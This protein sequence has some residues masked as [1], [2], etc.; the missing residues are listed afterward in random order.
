MSA[1]IS[2]PS[3]MDTMSLVLATSTNQEL[4]EKCSKCL[5]SLIEFAEDMDNCLPF[6][7]Q[8]ATRCVQFQF[9]TPK[10]LYVLIFFWH[11]WQ[12]K[13]QTNWTKKWYWTHCLDTISQNLWRGI[14]EALG[15]S[16]KTRDFSTALA[17]T[18]L[19]GDILA[20]S[21]ITS[22][23]L[24]FPDRED[25]MLEICDKCLDLI[26]VCSGQSDKKE[27]LK[28]CSTVAKLLCIVWTSLGCH[29]LPSFEALG[30]VLIN[31]R[32]VAAGIN[33]RY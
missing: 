2:D 8:C 11:F 17:F 19:M 16:C 25:L 5:A 9:F 3:V 20:T 12:M 21:E 6:F 32:A 13:S 7:R 14:V 31:S 15:Q 24:E 30:R 18:R 27:V 26:V 10:A 4:L 23:Q 22:D 28:D 29:H 33:D 1:A